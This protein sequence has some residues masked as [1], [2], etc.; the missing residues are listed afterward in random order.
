MPGVRSIYQ[1]TSRIKEGE[2]EEA[3]P[4]QGRQA[5]NWQTERRCDCEGEACA[6]EHGEDCFIFLGNTMIATAPEGMTKELWL[7]R[8]AARLTARVP[9]LI[10]ED[11]NY[12]AEACLEN[13][14][15][16]L[17]EHPEDAADEELSNWGD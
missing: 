8:C 15:G 17:M 10:A 5:S 6:D 2:S 4:A 14:D 11:A 7:K 9:D 1:R 13:L 12:I 16:D 3:R